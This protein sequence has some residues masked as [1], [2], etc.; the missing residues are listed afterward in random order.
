M[1]KP[2]IQNWKMYCKN[3]NFAGIGSTRKVYRVAD[4]VIKVHL[5]PLGYK[6]SQNEL[7]IYTSMVDKG[8][9]PLLA[10]TYF[11]DEFISVQQYFRPLELK[12]NQTYEIKVQEHQ[13]L[14]P[15]L[16]EE[17]L[18]I[19]DQ[20]FDCFDLKDSSNYGLNEECKL[21]FTDYGMTKSLYE[22]EWV[23]LAEEGILPQIHY[24]FCNECGIEKE[25][26]MYGKNDKDK[27][28]YECGKE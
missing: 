19:L 12:D 22:K 25:L 16:Y 5:H 21:V 24:D 8:L 1:L 27:R 26:R 7:E 18:A 15:N 20:Y 11:V 23:P 6:Q 3:E 10:P 13:H 2:I 4:Y 9:D 17:V 28:C 14:I